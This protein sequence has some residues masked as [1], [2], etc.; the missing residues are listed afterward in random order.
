MEDFGLD[1]G[2][3]RLDFAGPEIRFGKVLAFFFRDS[4]PEL[5]DDTIWI[6]NCPSWGQ[7][8][9]NLGSFELNLGFARDD[10]AK[11]KT[12]FRE[13]KFYVPKMRVS[14]SRPRHLGPT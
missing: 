3:P 14:D 4:W 13:L 11:N 6:A 9:A 2:G 12:C 10:F 1:F 8:E 7:L 5:A